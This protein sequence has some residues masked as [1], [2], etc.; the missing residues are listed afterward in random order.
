MG[1]IYLTNEQVDFLKYD[2]CFAD[3]TSPKVRYPVMRDALNATGRPIYFSMCEVE[4]KIKL[5]GR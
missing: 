3:K 4:N 2:N 1:S 5:V